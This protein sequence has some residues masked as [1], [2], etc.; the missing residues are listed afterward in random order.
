MVRIRKKLNDIVQLHQRIVTALKAQSARQNK[1]IEQYSDDIKQEMD[2][3]SNKYMYWTRIIK[4]YQ[5]SVISS[6]LID[7]DLIKRY[8][9]FVGDLLKYESNYII[10]EVEL[11]EL[12]YGFD[13]LVDVI[14]QLEKI[15]QDMRQGYVEPT[16]PI[17]EGID[18]TGVPEEESEDEEES[19]D[20]E[21]REQPLKHDAKKRVK[22]EPNK[23]LDQAQLTEEEL[24]FKMD[25]LGERIPLGLF[26]SLERNIV[27]RLLENPTGLPMRNLADIGSRAGA[28]KAMKKLESMKIV[29]VSMVGSSRLCKIHPNILEGIY[30]NK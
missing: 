19:D 27:K 6:K 28:H 21:T 7:F 22:K 4:P 20:K 9:D 8:E 23:I 30:D 1:L 18:I 16:T 5:E 2:I 10:N 15:I 12:E 24:K 11:E 3:P 14:L 25:K 17:D 13:Y 29:T 26:S